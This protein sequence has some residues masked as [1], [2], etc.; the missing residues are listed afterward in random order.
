MQHQILTPHRSSRSGTHLTPFGLLR[1]FYLVRSLSVLVGAALAA[2]LP[3]VAHA[4]GL[5]VRS[6]PRIELMSIVYHLAGSDI[7]NQGRVPSYTRDV[8]SAFAPF[9]DHRAVRRARRLEDTLGLGFDRPMF[10]ALQLADAHSLRELSPVD[11]APPDVPA[12]GWWPPA[13]ARGF[14]ADL[15]AFIHDAHTD[16]FFA[17]HAA[18]Y[19]TAARR[20]R[21]L[22]DSTADLPWF[23]R[24]FGHAPA[25]PFVVVPAL[26][27]GGANYGPRVR[28]QFYA[29]IGVEEVDSAGWPRFTPQYL[30]T[31]IH[32]FSHSF[33][34]PAIDRHA[35]DFEQ[36]GP[37]V[38]DAVR[39]QMK[40][41]AYE[42]WRTVIYESV[43]RAS[44]A[45][46][47]RSHEGPAAGLAE[48]V[49]QRANGFIWMGE[50]YDLLGDYENNRTHYP[51][52]ESFMPRLAAY[53]RS[54]PAHLPTLIAQYDSTRPR[55][56]SV[57]PADGSPDV[58][59]SLATLTIRFD[60]PMR[61]HW[62]LN[63]VR[64]DTLAQYPT[65]AG[66]PAYDSSHTVLTVPVRLAPGHS[67]AIALS[68]LGFRSADGSALELTVIHFRT[69]GSP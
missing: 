1:T 16:R 48:V 43:V 33:V 36:A 56:A 59:P 15:R 61:S 53:W 39:R 10:F 4:Q 5:I 50:L 30:P 45:R 52:L 66:K 19:D 51:D 55:V 65:I 31:I 22:M 28:S 26:L 62:S 8:D 63:P 34:N 64:D 25:K 20:M 12:D 13:E 46:Y 23:S 29:I 69:S 54:L 37:A 2:I 6:D 41:Q 3:A 9:R 11:V 32:E 47:R 49:D 35:A 21:R 57:N 24:F 27:N 7:Y 17:L 58:D 38:L 42:E 60:R 67:Y 40:Q 14:L 44:V 18:L 68:G